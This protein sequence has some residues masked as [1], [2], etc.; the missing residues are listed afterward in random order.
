MERRTHYVFR[1]APFVNCSD[2]DVVRNSSYGMFCTFLLF[3]CYVISKCNFCC[4]LHGI[5]TD[6][7]IIF[8]FLI[9]SK[10]VE[11][12]PLAEKLSVYRKNLDLIPRLA[13]EANAYRCF[14]EETAANRASLHP[15]NVPDMSPSYLSTVIKSL[16]QTR[17]R[18]HF[19]CKN[20][21]HAAFEIGECL[22]VIL[23][24][25]MLEENSNDRE[26]I[27]EMKQL[28]ELDFEE[29]E[30]LLLSVIH[31]LDVFLSDNDR[32]D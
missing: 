4:Q 24:C 8:P 27:M 22:A 28:A 31:D 30:R 20:V 23:S 26:K 18:V 10:G 6:L 7:F 17:D 9:F 21:W 32:S 11:T 15:L 25:K 2:P 1:I 13:A 12:L 19:Y 5:N 16:E 3:I 14:A 29:T